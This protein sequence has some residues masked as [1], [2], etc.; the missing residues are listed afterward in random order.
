[1]FLRI[2]V[3]WKRLAPV[4]F[5]LIADDKEE[6]GDCSKIPAGQWSFCKGWIQTDGCLKP[7]LRGH[8]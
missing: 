3:L 5:F 8:S 7:K 6:P 2:G 4:G 1:M